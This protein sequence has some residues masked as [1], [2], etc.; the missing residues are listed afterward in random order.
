MKGT[1]DKRRKRMLKIEQQVTPRGSGPY[2][3]KAG[4]VLHMYA[5]YLT[6]G[7]YVDVAPVIDDAFVTRLIE[8]LKRDL[9]RERRREAFRE[10]YFQGKRSEKEQQQQREFDESILFH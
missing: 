9:A 6:S 1:R 5:E 10:E 7:R 2:A 8:G 3:T 4:W